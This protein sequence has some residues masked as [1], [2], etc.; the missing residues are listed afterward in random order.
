MGKWGEKGVNINKRGV[1]GRNC[2]DMMS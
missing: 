2:G 1:L